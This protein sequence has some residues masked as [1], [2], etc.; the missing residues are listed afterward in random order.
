MQIFVKTI[1]GKTITLNVHLTDTVHQLRMMIF[2][3][4]NIPLN[5]QKIIYQTK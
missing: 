1:T 4:E 3:K 5:Q 2:D